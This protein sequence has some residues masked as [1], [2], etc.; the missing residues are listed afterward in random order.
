[1]TGGGHT[2]VIRRVLERRA[3]KAPTE[4]GTTATV[5]VMVRVLPPPKALLVFC[6]PLLLQQ[7]ERHVTADVLDAELLSDEHDALRRLNAEFRPVV[8][9]DSLELI[10]NLRARPAS[11]APFVVYI[12]ELD[13][14]GEREAG[15]SAGA[16]E[17]VGRRAT[18]PELIARIG[19]ARRIAELETALRITL[20]E[21]RQLSTTD[22]LTRTASRRFFG[23]HFPRE[24]ERAARYGRALSLILCDIDHFKNINDTLGHPSGDQVL[25]HFGERLKLGLRQGVDWVA[26]IGGE[27]FAVVTPESGYESALAVARK[28]RSEVAQ[29]PFRIADRVLPVT[30][31]FGVCGLDRVPAG[32]RRLAERM[33][34]IADQALYRSKGAG[35][36]RVTATRLELRSSPL[37][38]RPAGVRP[39]TSRAAS[40]PP[41]APSSPDAAS[42]DDSA[43]REPTRVMRV[44]R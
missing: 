44:N 31:S 43:P 12:A 1:M 26:R 8:L 33:L 42:A 3:E 40:I 10:R 39:V 17:C 38:P 29:T 11:R 35:R 30:A 25:R 32:E 21:N 20:E 19:S 16:D 37:A 2:T 9:T 18:G 23:K 15:L 36:D 5:A 14:A 41:V 7:I 4:E 34:K 22:E 28:L 24:V 27:E 13:E 6:N